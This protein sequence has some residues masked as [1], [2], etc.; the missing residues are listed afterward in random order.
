MWQH[1][2]VAEKIIF[3]IDGEDK[4]EKNRK[5]IPIFGERIVSVQ[6]HHQQYFGIYRMSLF[7]LLYGEGQLD[8]DDSY[9]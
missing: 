1:N 7:L 6:R 2:E 3:N 8:A 9:E 5:N 4:D